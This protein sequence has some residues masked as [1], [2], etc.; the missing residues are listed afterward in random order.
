MQGRFFIPLVHVTFFPFQEISV[1]FS[2]THP[3]LLQS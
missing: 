3:L 1:P 2:L